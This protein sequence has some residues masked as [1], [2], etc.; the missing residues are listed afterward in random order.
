MK[1]AVCLSGQPRTWKKCFNS[2]NS[3]FLRLKLEYGAEIDIFAHLWDYNTP[4][5]GVL[6][7]SDEVRNENGD[8][9]TVK[10]K[11]ITEEEKNDILET[12]NPKSYL[13]EGEEV[14]KEKPTECREESK[15]YSHMYGEIMLDWAAGQFYSM[16]MSTHLKK[17]YEFEND[18]KYDVCIRMRCDLFFSDDQINYF[19]NK[20]GNEFMFPKHNTIYSCH[21]NNLKLGDI[22]FYSNSVTFD[23]ICD[24]YRWIPIM[25]TKTFPLKHKTLGTED[26]IYF[27]MR[28]LKIDVH[29]IYV[30]P[31][32]YREENYL[33]LKEKSGLMEGL[34]VHEII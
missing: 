9:L 4:P 13:F 32:I 23:R 17:K 34:G 28:M 18:F 22:F 33:E 8:Y 29:P 14:N 15:K 1:I 16:M 19:L 7:R 10:G 12:L 24:F 25:S 30:N 21:T 27:Y 20:Q 26:A 6:M 3:L 5:H 31:K 11:K 2:W